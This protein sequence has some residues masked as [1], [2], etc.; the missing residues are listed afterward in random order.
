MKNH[1][2][3]ISYCEFETKD[4]LNESDKFLLTEAEKAM[5]LAYSPYSGFSVG[6]A[7]LLGNG[8]VFTGNN[9]E[10]AAYPS[11]L[12]AERV[13]MFA[14]ASQYPGILFVSIAVTAMSENFLVN[15]PVSPCGSCRQVMAEYENSRKAQMRIILKGQTGKVVVFNKSNDLLPFVFNS[16]QLKSK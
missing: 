11:G 15:Y 13:A 2:L 9:Q 7:L 4:D 12:C 10:N 3:S 16:D 5:Q 6:A 14:A 8:M 1:T